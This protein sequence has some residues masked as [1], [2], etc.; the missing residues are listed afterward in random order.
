VLFG[1]HIEIVQVKVGSF[2]E[3]KDGRMNSTGGFAALAE[4]V[5]KP[6]NSLFSRERLLLK[7]DDG[8][9]GPSQTFSAKRT[10]PAALLAWASSFAQPATFS[11]VPRFKAGTHFSF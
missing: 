11:V 9:A 8:F 4:K 2:H 7:V 5:F 10:M 1:F 6:I 3:C